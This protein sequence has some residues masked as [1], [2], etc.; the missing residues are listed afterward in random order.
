VRR[1]RRRGRASEAGQAAG[2]RRR[3]APGQGEPR[4]LAALRFDSRLVFSLALSS[5]A[6]WRGVSLAGAGRGLISAGGALRWNAVACGALFVLLGWGLSRTGRKAHFEPAAVHLGWLL[7]LGGLAGGIFDNGARG[8]G[9]AA[10]LL[11]VGAGLAAA[12]GG[13]GRPGRA[14]AGALGRRAGAYRRRRPLRGRGRERRLLRRGR[15]FPRRGRG[16]RPLRR[17][18]ERRLLRRG[19]RFPRRGRGRRPLRRGRERR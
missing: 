16:R 8:L 14:D 13:S 17:G 7:V 10:A 15:R 6:A 1:R 3:R 12:S 2:E 5:F 4:A 9:W 18:R 11:G 19:R